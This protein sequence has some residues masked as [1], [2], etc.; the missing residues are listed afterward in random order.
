ME[1]VAYPY[2]RPRWFV[3][4]MRQVPDEVAHYTAD[5]QAR[6]ELEEPEGMEWHS[7]VMAGSR[8]R[9]GV[10]HPGDCSVRDNG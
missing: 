3:V 9:F 1:R 5:Y 10:E 8:L 4:I 6:Y 2:E 7:W